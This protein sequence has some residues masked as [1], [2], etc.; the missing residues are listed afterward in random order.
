MMPC[1]HTVSMLFMM[2]SQDTE[3]VLHDD[4]GLDAFN[5]L[6]SNTEKA[7]YYSQLAYKA[8]K[9]NGIDLNTGKGVSKIP[10]T[11]SII[12]PQEIWSG[13]AHKKARNT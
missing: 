5:F 8:Y 9:R 4:K 6:N 12:F 11:K 10:G 13:C 7:F 1:K 2:C 3:S